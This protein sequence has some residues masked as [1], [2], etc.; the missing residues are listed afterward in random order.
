MR[1]RLVKMLNAKQDYGVRCF[2]NENGQ[3]ISKISN[4]YLSDFLLTKGVIALDTEKVNV[5]MNLNPIVTAFGMPLDELAEL[6]RAKEEGR[7]IVLPYKVGDIVYH[8]GEHIRITDSGW[9][10]IPRIM[11]EKFHYGMLDWKY[12]TLYPTREEAEQALKGGVE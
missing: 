10:T 12:T 1:D 8:I 3:V 9:T 7:L 11:A 5:A 6:I 4:E 2:Y